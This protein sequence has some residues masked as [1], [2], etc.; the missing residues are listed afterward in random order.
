MLP[1]YNPAQHLP[2]PRNLFATLRLALDPSRSGQY[3]AYLSRRLT[4][5]LELRADQPI[6]LLPPASSHPW[7]HLDVRPQ[8]PNRLRWYADTRPRI[9][10]LL[11]PATV[12][13]GQQHLTL[14]LVPGDPAYPGYYPLLPDAFFAP[15]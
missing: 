13:A 2:P 5:A 8:A 15:R 11:L 6:D 10:G 9:Q 12:L 14:Q 1:T 3:R 4:D 7:W